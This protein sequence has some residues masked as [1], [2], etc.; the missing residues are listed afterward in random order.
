MKLRGSFY[1]G[2]FYSII[3]NFVL[4]LIVLGTC[5]P[6]SFWYNFWMTGFTLWIVGGL[7]Y[8]FLA[9]WFLKKRYNTTFPKE[10]NKVYPGPMNV[11]SVLYR[12]II[13]L[14]RKES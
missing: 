10:F 2:I 13:R 1:K 12:L 4:L 6:G 5:T 9:N 8:F 7:T 3:E 11:T 14:S